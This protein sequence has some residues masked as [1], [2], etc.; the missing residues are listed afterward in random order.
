MNPAT[1]KSKLAVDTYEKIAGKYAQQYFDDMGDLPYIDKFLDKL[2][3]KGKILDV[4]SGP[5][6]FAK[7]MSRKGFEVIGID[8]SKKMISIAKDKV[9]SVDFRYMDM[10]QL[11]FSDNSFDGIFSAYSLIHIA[12]KE[13][14]TTL[15]GFYRV[16]KTG[17]YVEI[18]VQKGEADKIIDEPF[19]PTE[20]MFFNFFKEE[21]IAKYLEDA[22]FQV[23]SQELMSIDDTE[24]MSDKVIYTI[25]KKEY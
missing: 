6:Q 20:K 24:T 1:D 10:R 5:G 17:G 9:S 14:L 19:M 23:V 25:A 16:L 8:F 11:D 12:S 4:G 3:K 2:P 18:A 22:G 7:H 21:R 15:K 13:V